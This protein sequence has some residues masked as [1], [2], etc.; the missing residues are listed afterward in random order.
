MASDAVVEAL[1]CERATFCGDVAAIGVEFGGYGLGVGAGGGCWV[2]V[3]GWQQLRRQERLSGN[4]K[5]AE[6]DTTKPYLLLLAKCGGV[7]EQDT[8]KPYLL[9]LAKCGGVSEQDTT[10]PYMLLL[11]KCGGV[12]EQDTT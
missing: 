11:A 4:R 6:Q 9:L 10:K 3:Q 5:V 7:P 12:P 1:A 2:Y 8:T